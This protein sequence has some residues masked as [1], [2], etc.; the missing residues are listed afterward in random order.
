MRIELSPLSGRH[1]LGYLLG[2][3]ELELRDAIEQAVAGN[4]RTV[5][6]V[7]AA[8]GYYTIGFA[9]RLPQARVE[10][11]EAL[12]ELHPVIT[13]TARVNG[14]EN[15]IGIHGLC[16]AERLA[17]QLEAAAGPTLVV[18]DI[19]GGEAELLDPA[20]V[21]QLAHA[22]ILV[23]THDAFVAG[24]TETLMDRFGAMHDI[25]CYSARPRT[26]NDF[27]PG[28]LPWFR[29][30]FPHLAIELMNERR[31]GL[32]RWLLLSAKA[33]QAKAAAAETAVAL[34]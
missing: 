14:V 20:A 31:T 2:S 8:D 22:D 15:R 12:D 29:R 10:A 34:G 1:L 13:R 28:F 16:T 11:F 9:M 19:E 24:V 7:G 3:Q 21:P 27:P 17:E 5:I 30:L 4:Y 23:E 6:N 26:L 32:Q 33:S 18:M 25:T